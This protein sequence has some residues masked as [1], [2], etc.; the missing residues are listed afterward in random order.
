MSLVDSGTDTIVRANMDNDS[1]FEF[2]LVI[3]DG[4]VHASAY[5][6]ADFIL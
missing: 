6:A 3:H 2:R 5:T 4:S 1:A